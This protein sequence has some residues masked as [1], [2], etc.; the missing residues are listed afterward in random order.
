MKRGGYVLGDAS[1]ARAAILATGSE[2]PLALAA[3]AALAAAGV[4]SQYAG[5]LAAVGALFLLIALLLSFYR[6]SGNESK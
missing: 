5:W 3:Q 2:V 6:G 4:F 1:D